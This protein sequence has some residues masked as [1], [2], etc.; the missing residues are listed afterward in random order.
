[1]TRC[2]PAYWICASHS[3]VDWKAPENRPPV[4]LKT[5]ATIYEAFP[6]EDVLDYIDWNPF[7][8]VRCRLH[9]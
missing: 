8:Q 6:L 2:M 1:M 3:Q 5:G 9:T 4:P 7:F